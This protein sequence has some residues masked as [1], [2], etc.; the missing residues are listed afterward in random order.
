MEL[1][2]YNARMLRLA[3]EAAGAG[4]LADADGSAEIVNPVCGDRIR[5]DVRTEGARIRAIGYEVHAC[6]LTQ[7][8]ASL[9]GR[10]ARGRTAGEIREVAERIEAMLRGDADAPGGDWAAYAALEPVRAHPS[11]HECVMLPLRALLAALDPDGST[12]RGSS[13]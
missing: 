9:L 3:A 5:V 7:A 6:V 12:D 2:I 4:R 10:H 1:G 13:G 11:R 8:S